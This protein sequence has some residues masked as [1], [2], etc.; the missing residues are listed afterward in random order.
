MFNHQLSD[1]KRKNQQSVKKILLKVWWHGDIKCET[2]ENCL[3]P[4]ILS[5]VYIEELISL[6]NPLCAMMQ[7]YSSCIYWTCTIFALMEWHTLNQVLIEDL[8]YIAHLLHHESL[9]SAHSQSLLGAV[10]F[11]SQQINYCFN[12]SPLKRVLKV[13]KFNLQYIW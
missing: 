9:P 10:V 13:L 2:I 8:I 1:Q 11:E 5:S 7:K 3:Q 6:I 4:V 12:Y